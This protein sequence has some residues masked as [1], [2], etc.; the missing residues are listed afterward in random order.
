MTAAEMR[1][2]L[3]GYGLDAKGLKADL[4]KRL[5]EARAAPE[6]DGGDEEE[7]DP[8]LVEMMRK[9]A[10]MEAEAA[11]LEAAM[12][13]A[14]DGEEAGAA[15]GSGEAAPSGRRAVRINPPGRSRRDR[16]GRRAGRGDRT[17]RR[18]SKTCPTTP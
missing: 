18:P 14:G 3:K 11:A 6:P 12:Q 13:G 8:E 15:D 4:T 7:E 9:V 1:E 5:E 2:E 16:R 10:E 17:R